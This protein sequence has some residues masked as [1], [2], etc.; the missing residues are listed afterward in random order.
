MLFIF[1][2][3]SD[4][5]KCISWLL[6]VLIQALSLNNLNSL[7][8]K[9]LCKVRPVAL[10]LESNHVRPDKGLLE[11]LGG[12]SLSPLSIDMLGKG[13]HFLIVLTPNN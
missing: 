12:S 7:K 8:L 10:I 6:C 3:D 5:S 9:I 1:P 2:E 11:I 4:Y 13:Q